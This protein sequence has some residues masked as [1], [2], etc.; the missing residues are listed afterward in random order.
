LPEIRAVVVAVVPSILKLTVPVG[1]ADS[2][3]VGITDAETDSAAPP[4][5]VVVAGVTVVAV[6][7]F[8]TVTVAEVEVEAA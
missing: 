8:G 7:T 6:V 2:V 3:V 1:N 5:G 4:E